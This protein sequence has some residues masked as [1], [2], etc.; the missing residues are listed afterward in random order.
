MQLY[1][2]TLFESELN[3]DSHCDYLKDKKTLLYIDTP[4]S[5]TNKNTIEKVLGLKLLY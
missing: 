4:R 5:I 1:S 3:V 2:A